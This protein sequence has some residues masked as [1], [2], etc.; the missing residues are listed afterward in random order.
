ML[1]SKSDIERRI[2]LGCAAFNNLSKV[3]NSKIPLT[4]RLLLYNALVVSVFMYYSCCWAAPQNVIERLDVAHR[5]HLR[6]L[7]KIRYPSVI[8]NVNLYKRCNTE[9]LS[10][11]VDRS[12]WRMIGHVL[13]GPTDGPAFTSLVFAI[14]TLNLPGRRGRPQTN[15]F[16]LLKRDLNDKNL[17]LNN[18]YDLF[19]IR[20]KALNRPLWA[21]LGRNVDC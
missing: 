1:C 16:S 12:R 18:L 10:V 5:R 19:Y 9:P 7:L 8:S 20:T 13:R 15:L 3:W 17:S 2:N 4:K 21:S 14:N 6:K 11:K